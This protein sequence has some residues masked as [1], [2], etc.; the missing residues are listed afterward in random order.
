MRGRF[1]FAFGAVL[2]ACG[3]TEPS[4]PPPPPSGWIYYAE[5]RRMLPH[6]KLLWRIRPDG[7]GREQVPNPDEVRA[8]PEFD[9]TR[10]GR[11]IAINRASTLMIVPIATPTAP[12]FVTEVDL[13]G[14]FRWSPSGRVLARSRIDHGT[15]RKQL[16]LTSIDGAPETLL[17]E[18]DAANGFR[19]VEWFTDG[20]SL[21]YVDV[22]RGVR[23]LRLKDL[24]T[25]AVTP[26]TDWIEPSP[27]GR[28]GL[29]WQVD[30]VDYDTKK[31]WRLYDLSTGQLVR[32]V[33]HRFSPHRLA[34]SP[35]ER[36]FVD[37]CQELSAGL[38]FLGL[39]VYD[40]ATLLPITRLADPTPDTYLDYPRWIP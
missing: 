35:D 6:Q 32:E 13:A 1:V 4:V 7:T 37:L 30:S 10:D 29:E 16:V 2:T 23:V 20:D 39:C 9:V 24:S 22:R 17:L 34:W 15:G 31:H 14:H 38:E 11:M 18:T 27:S 19:P 12:Y 8:G 28:F 26:L 3:A 33:T 25:R 5:G 36:H 40:R 21:V